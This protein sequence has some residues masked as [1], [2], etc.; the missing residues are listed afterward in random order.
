MS[1]AEFLAIV[2]GVSACLHIVNSTKKILMLIRSGPY[3][4]Q[5]TLQVCGILLRCNYLE[6]LEKLHD[7]TD[8]TET[9][10]LADICHHASQ[11]LKTLEALLAPHDVSERCS[12]RREIFNTL[13]QGERIKKAQ[14]LLADLDATLETTYRLISIRLQHRTYMIV[15]Q[16]AQQSQTPVVNL[17]LDETNGPASDTRLICENENAGALVQVH[18]G[19]LMGACIPQP[20]YNSRCSRGTCSC[21][22]HGLSKDVYRHSWIEG[23]SWLSFITKC[24]C[25]SK[26]FHWSVNMFQKQLSFKILV[27][28]QRGFSLNVS[29]PIRNTVPRTSPL[30]VVLL[31]CQEGLM[32]LDD[33]LVSIREIL[34][35]R[36]GSIYDINHNGEG[37]FEV[38]APKQYIPQH[39]TCE[40]EA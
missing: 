9:T 34:D 21:R 16:T 3:G 18:R 39:F 5:L 19:H 24:A 1:G 37:W 10:A 22:C 32:K 15:A 28:Y 13:K 7:L 12:K 23:S 33:A 35:A 4:E 2:G 40:S 38:S 11:Q 25:D 30:F 36:G 14:K 17:S 8:E 31:K 26:T 27:E 6:E 29:L 20:F